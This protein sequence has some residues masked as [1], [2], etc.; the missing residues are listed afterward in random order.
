MVLRKAKECSRLSFFF[1]NFRLSFFFEKAISGEG[2]KGAIELENLQKISES[3]R[4]K[5]TKKPF[6]FKGDEIA[7][8]VKKILGSFFLVKKN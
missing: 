1:W 5:L 6:S 4:V 8:K 3:S 7:E 2:L